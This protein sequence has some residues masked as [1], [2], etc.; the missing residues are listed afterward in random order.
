MNYKS[1]KP[2]FLRLNDALEQ[3][4]VF[5]QD[6][7]SNDD[8]FK[9]FNRVV[10]VDEHL[11]RTLT[12]GTAFEIEIAA[13]V[14]TGVADDEDLAIATKRATAVIRA[15]FLATALIKRSGT[16]YAILR[17]DLENAYVLSDDKYPSDLTIALGILNAY[18]GPA[19]ER[20]RKDRTN[21]NSRTQHQFAHVN[22]LGPAPVAVTNGRV[23][24]GVLCYACNCIGH[25][26][27]DCRGSASAAT[28]GAGAATAA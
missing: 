9:A 21:Q 6:S 19:K 20:E 7:K 13:R 27:M 22:S 15:K 24:D 8:Y 10:S 5:R 23:W 26:E 28:A 4:V 1:T 3:Y 18:I 25:Y 14:A 11:G 12:H 17:R 16:R 2:K